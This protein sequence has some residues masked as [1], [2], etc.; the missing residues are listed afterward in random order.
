M[1][2]AE[3]E[4]CGV[5]CPRR[6]ILKPL[7]L[8]PRWC[9]AGRREQIVQQFAARRQ[10]H[11]SNLQIPQAWPKS[12]DELSAPA[13][14]KTL[15]KLDVFFCLYVATSLVRV[16][17]SLSALVWMPSTKHRGLIRRWAIPSVSILYWS[18]GL[19]FVAVS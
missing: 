4:M 5:D 2:W 17:V 15:V 10:A 7:E 3:E 14:S 6:W 18:L 19:Q 9:A 16:W 11:N 12:G 13:L 1:N 8:Q